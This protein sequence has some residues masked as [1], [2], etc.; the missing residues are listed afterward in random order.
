MLMLLMM[1]T[2]FLWVGVGTFEREWAWL[3]IAA[4]I[5]ARHSG[6]RTEVR[7]RLRGRQGG[8]PTQAPAWLRRLL[9][10]RPDNVFDAGLGWRSRAAIHAL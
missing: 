5:K 3:Q 8:P 6:Q 7:R 1:C 9:C 4:E 2:Y 10:V